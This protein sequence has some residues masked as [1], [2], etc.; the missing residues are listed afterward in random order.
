M[1]HLIIIGLLMGAFGVSFAQNDTLS[2]Q[3]Q[4]QTRYST[5]LG[6]SSFSLGGYYRFYGINRTLEQPFRV[7]PDNQFAN[8][9]PF[10]LGVG[11][12]YIDPPIMLMTASIRAGGGAAINMDYAL[13]NNIG[14]TPGQVPYNLN[15]GISLYGTVPTDF[16]RFGFQL[17]GIHWTDVSGMVFS[18]FVGYNRFSIFERWAW[19]GLGQGEKRAENYLEKGDIARESRWARQ[20]FKGALVDVDELPYNLSARVLFGKTPATAAL[21]IVNSNYTTGGRLR[22]S[23]SGG[24]VSFNTMNYVVYTDSIGLERGGINLHTLSAGKK[25]DKWEIA[26]EGG[27]GQLVSATQHEGFGEALRLKLRSEDLIPF[28]PLEV[29][30]FRISPQFVN[31]YGNFISFNTQIVGTGQA[32]VING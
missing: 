3:N 17:G 13:F 30:V 26:F 11:D 20:A 14:G 21:G 25:T 2:W 9:P 1:K 31:F 7:L 32:Q 28:M 4:T 18:S 12:V 8:T 5:A 6:G 27:I 16:A 29:E 15:L 19:E 24:D 23:F 10:I 22:Y